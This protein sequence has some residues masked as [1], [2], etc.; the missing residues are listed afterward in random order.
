[1]AQG[2]PG[3]GVCEALGCELHDVALALGPGAHELRDAQLQ[4]RVLGEVPARAKFRSDILSAIRLL[5]AS[6]YG[7]AWV[8]CMNRVLSP[9]AAQSPASML[10]NIVL[11]P[12]L[13]QHVSI[14]TVRHWILYQLHTACV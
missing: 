14:K 10:V 9:Q 5:Y 2:A 1:V 4:D 11:D 7:C 3:A 8:G 6:L 13:V 12:S